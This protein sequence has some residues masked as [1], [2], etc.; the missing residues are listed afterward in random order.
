MPNMVVAEAA[1]L[2]VEPTSMD[3][4]CAGTVTQGA[5]TTFAG[6]NPDRAGQ[7]T[8]GCDSRDGVCTGRT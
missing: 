8:M 7:A 3:A 4:L 1:T 6:N 2:D 5:A